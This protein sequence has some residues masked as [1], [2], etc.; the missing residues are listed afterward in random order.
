MNPLAHYHFLIERLLGPDGDV[1]AAVAA[2]IAPLP[3]GDPDEIETHL[4]VAWDL[5]VIAAADT[6]VA[7][8]TLLVDLV[9]GVQRHELPGVRVWAQRV[10]TD[11]PLLGDRLSRAWDE[12]HDP[13]DWVRLNAFAARLTASVADFLPLG[14]RTIVTALEERGPLP[15][16]IE[17][18]RHAGTQLV[19]ACVHGRTYAGRLGDPAARAEGGF[20]VTRWIAW[21]NA[22]ADRGSP[23]GVKLMSRFD[24][25]IAA[26]FRG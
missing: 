12:P 13:D 19:D 26:H 21:R 7:S 3:P 8:Q 25:R 23:D 20:S 5:L 6:P 9:A 14:L 10:L 2:F 22:L 1:D 16:A 15:P 18:F 24:A 11:L 17:W 4:E